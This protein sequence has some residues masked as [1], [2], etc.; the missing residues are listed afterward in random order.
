MCACVRLCIYIH[1]PVYRDVVFSLVLDVDDEGVAV[2]GLEGRPREHPVHG[3]D[4]VGLAQPLHW[5]FLN[6]LKFVSIHIT[7]NKQ[8]KME[9][10]KS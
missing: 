6:L 7:H 1:I 8:L 2:L 10:N 5:R 3:D 9:S 4:I